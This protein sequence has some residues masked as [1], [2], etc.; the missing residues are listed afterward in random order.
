M[1]TALSAVGLLAVASLILSAQSLIAQTTGEIRRAQPVNEPPVRPA[2]PYQPPPTSQAPVVDETA[3][4]EPAETA[5]PAQRQLEYADALFGRKLYDLAIP[6][7]QKYLDNYPGASGRAN[8]LFCLGECYRA[9]NK[10]SAARKN[11][12]AVLDDYGDSEFAGPAAYILAETAFTEKNYGAALPL[13]HRAGSKSKEPAVVLSAR[14][15]EA[16]CLEALDRKDEAAGIYQ[17]VIDAKNPNPFREDS[18]Y[19]AASILLSRGRKS[20]ALKQ[21]EALSNEAQKP[22]LRAEAAVRGGLIAV[23][24]VQAEKGKIDKGMLEKATSLLQRARSSPEAGKY[25]AIAEVGLLRLQYQS[26][27]YAQL[28]S[29][30]KKEQQKLPDD[31]RPEAMLLAANA[32]R[33][34][35]HASEAEALYDE[36]LAKYPNREDAKEA[37]YQRLINIYNSDPAKLSDAIDQFLATDPSPERADQAKLLKAEALYKQQD[38]SAAAPIYADLRASRLSPKLR[39]EASYK[40]GLCYVQMKDVGRIVEAFTYYVQAFPDTPQAPAAFAQRAIAN[41]EQKNY[42]AALADLNTIL[43]RYSGAAEREASFQQKALI[44]GQE[45]NGKG[46]SD[47]F[48]Q[49]LKEFPKTAAAAQAQYYIGKT[50][51]EAKDYKAAISALNTARQFNKQQYYDVATIRIISSYFYLR[52]RAA[53]TKEVDGFMA[54][55]SNAK[56]PAEILEWLGIE[57]YNEKNY[58]AAEKYLGA[59]GQIDNPTTAKPDFWFYLGDAAT[60]LQNFSEAENAYAHYLQVAT[61]PAGK[62]KVLLALGAAKIGA[63]KPDEAQK[64][65]EEIMSLQPEGRVNAEAR[66]LAGDVQVERGKFDEAGKAFM[67]VAL[68]YDDPAITPRALQKAASAYQRAGKMDEAD[69]ATRQLHDKYP[70]YASGSG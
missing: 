66:L 7:F 48:K 38:F 13:F 3:Q 33:Q 54:T 41:R 60:R 47:T 34:L 29:D 43:T 27:Q 26:G 17:Q 70:N 4:P 5:P 6:E 62:A 24:L 49:L 22:S 50:A 31:A 56:V 42:D 12:Q 69:R 2:I 14:Y 39:A 1:K 32:E 20:D 9:L 40:L 57:Y 51:F 61:D 23:D 68:L 45:G 52:D 63:H 46:M 10:N 8:A 21:Y 37:Q 44:L 36:I 65:A 25:R 28:V 64:I 35:G 19:A 18:R 16:R 67:G 59:L 11:F 58:A 53:L 30:Y 15:F 55:N